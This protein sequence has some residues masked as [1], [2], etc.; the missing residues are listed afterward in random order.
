MKDASSQHLQSFLR[1]LGFSDSDSTVLTALMLSER[2]L[3]AAELA[4]KT[5]YSAASISLSLMRLRK[6][7]VVEKARREGRNVYWPSKGLA[8]SFNLFVKDLL[9][10]HIKPFMKSLEEEE[11]GSVKMKIMRELK[12]LERSLKNIIEGGY[13][14]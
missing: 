3:T 9:G 10:G 5:G 12:S 6:N 8:E 4:R 14:P 2:P 11:V 13:E 7:H 1:R